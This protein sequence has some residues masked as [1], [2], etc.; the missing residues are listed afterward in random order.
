MSQRHDV[1]LGEL[2]ALIRSARGYSTALKTRLERLIEGSFGNDVGRFLASTDADM[3]LLRNCG[4]TTAELARIVKRQCA[5]RIVSGERY[6]L[7]EIEA[8]IRFLRANR[9]LPVVA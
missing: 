6:T 2:V 8:A 5:T 9:G 1:T 4:R 3:L 7:C